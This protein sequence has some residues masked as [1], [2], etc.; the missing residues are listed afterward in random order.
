MAKSFTVPFFDSQV[1]LVRTHADLLRECEKNG[2]DVPDKNTDGICIQAEWDS[3]RTQFILGWMSKDVSVLC[4]EAVHLAQFILLRAGIDP[5]D[6]N[7]ETM[8]YLV[9]WIVDKAM[10]VK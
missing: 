2:V 7:G 4:H 6:S 10:R 8:A 1:T 5:R 9:G 3:G